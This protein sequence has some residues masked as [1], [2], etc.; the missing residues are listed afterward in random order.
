[1]YTRRRIFWIK[2]K[3]KST[4]FPNRQT[5]HTHTHSL[6]I[7]VCKVSV[8]FYFFFKRVRVRYIFPSHLYFSRFTYIC[9]YTHTR[10]RNS[11]DLVVF[12][13]VLIASKEHVEWITF[14]KHAI[15]IWLSCFFLLSFFCVFL[16]RKDN[17]V[18]MWGITVQKW[19]TKVVNKVGCF[20][21][22]IVVDVK[23]WMYVLGM[24]KEGKCYLLK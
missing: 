17:N 1:M 21:L 14:V 8:F 9:T 4:P 2:L 5:T 3:S 19:V 10:T 11:H 16:E 20:S 6:F 24:K 13:P 23:K 12:F 15:S 18:T 22:F 7:S